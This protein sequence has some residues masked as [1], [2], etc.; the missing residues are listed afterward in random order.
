MRTKLATAEGARADSYQTTRFNALRHG[1]LSRHTVLP[2]EDEGEYRAL[3]DA[4]VDEHSPSGPTEEHLIEE[5]AGIIWRKRRLRMAEAAAY[6]E[7]LRHKATDYD[8]PDQIAGAALLPLTGASEGR[9]SISRAIAATPAET[10][11]DL[12]DVNRDQGMTQR[13]L[14][15]LQTGGVRHLRTGAGC[16]AQ[17]H[18]GSLGGM[19][20]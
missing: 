19:P 3:L 2:W 10:G 7:K 17:R 12:R 11:R 6:R 1:V 9:A 5:L 13:A 8:G 20:S 4:L 14:N 18:K 16:V 15:I